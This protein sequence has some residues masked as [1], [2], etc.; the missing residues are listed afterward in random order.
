MNFGGIVNQGPDDHYPNQQSQGRPPWDGKPSR[1]PLTPPALPPQW[2]SD[3]SQRDYVPPRSYPASTYYS[4][5]SPS[6]GYR[7]TVPPTA[8]PRPERSKRTGKRNAILIG[9]AGLFFVGVLSTVL[10]NGG[11]W[12]GTSA[13][14]TSTSAGQ[15]SSGLSAAEKS[16]STR[17]TAAGDIYVRTI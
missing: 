17:S 15:V 6:P 3:A 1:R 8:P 12:P 5:A 2:Q 7:L 4:P 10:G 14:L 13:A 11:R 9:V 16:C